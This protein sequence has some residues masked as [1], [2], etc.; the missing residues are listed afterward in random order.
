MPLVFMRILLLFLPYCLV[1]VYNTFLIFRHSIKE[2]VYCSLTNKLAINEIVLIS[3]LRL[4]QGK[5]FTIV[6]IVCFFICLTLSIPE[7]Q[8]VVVRSSVV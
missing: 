3:S 1:A 2:M 4:E 8:L 7:S 6:V 5:R